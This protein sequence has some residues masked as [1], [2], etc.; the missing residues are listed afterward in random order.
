MSALWGALERWNNPSVSRPAFLRGLATLC[1]AESIGSDTSP[2]GRVRVVPAEEARHLD[3]DYLFVIGLGEKSFPRLGSPPSL[4]DDADRAQLRKASLPFPNPAERL[5]TEQLLFLD[6]VARPRREL[7]L[8]YEAIDEKGQPLLPGT[9]L[10]AVHECFAADVLQ[11]ERQRMLIEGYTTREP[12]SP[13]EARVQFA[14]NMS[15]RTDCA[16]W[17]HPNLPGELCEHLRW[18][19][20][21]ADA[22]FRSR[23]YNRFD[24]WVDTSA[25]LAEVRA[26][27]G[28]THVFS[29]TALETYVACPFKFLLGHVLK[30][31]ELDEPGEEV[32][33]TRRGAAYHRAL[34]R[35]H[36]KL[37]E[38]DPEMTRARL[39]EHVGPELRAQIDLA[40][41]EY[42][43]RAPSAASKKLWELEG[44]RLHRSAAHYCDHWDR[45]VDPWRKANAPPSPHLLEADFGVTG[46]PADSST[47]LVISVGGVEVRIGGRIDRVDVA[48]LD[49]EL[50]FWVIDYKTGR[51]Q[52][53]TSAGLARLEQMQ[54]SLYA[55]AVEK[56]F[57]PG[58]KARP[59]GLAYWLVTDTGPKGV[60]PRQAMAWHSDP[61]AWAKFRGQLEGWVAKL[62]GRLREGRFPLAPRSDNCTETCQFGQVC[63]I[64]QSRNLGKAWDL[65]PG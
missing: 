14:A 27:F 13:A 38:I 41:Q 32:E 8:S 11:P 37:R 25:A 52:N 29:P 20:E 56:V 16:A 31:E 22:R 19:K 3:C 4:L 44:K 46:A 36:R 21:V 43:A 47:P 54:L 17:R 40:V 35:L 65:E 6:L 5:G 2:A 10:R 18:A 61:D 24:G 59:L 1:A 50:G 58:R 12:L 49:G 28:P 57:L 30:L 26:R 42:A 64:S 15:G 62:V 9:F 34:A 53:Y 63:R 33:Q 48:E 51:S 45:Y 55:L 39:P 23:D 7:I 60:L